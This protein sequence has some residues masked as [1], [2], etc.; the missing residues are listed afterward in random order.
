MEMIMAILLG[1]F[2]GTSIGTI[3]WLF[4][5]ILLNHFFRERF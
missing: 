4:I 2:L 1:I 3:L 5:V